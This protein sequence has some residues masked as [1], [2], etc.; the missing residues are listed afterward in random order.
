MRLFRIVMVGMLTVCTLPF[1][2]LAISVALA[3]FGQCQLDEGSV[4]TC[5][6]AGL[7][8]GPTLYTMSVGAWFGLV[9]LPLLAAT[10]LLWAAVELFRWLRGREQTTLP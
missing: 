4:H 10:L 9:T 3:D 6:I 2:S 1:L 8:L 5:L 7:D